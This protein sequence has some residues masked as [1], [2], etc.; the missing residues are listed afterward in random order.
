M[1]HRQPHTGTPQ[2]ILGVSET[3]ASS[4]LGVNT[5]I[6]LDEGAALYPGECTGIVAGTDYTALY[7]KFHNTSVST[8]DLATPNGNA[9]SVKIA[10]G[11]DAGT[12]SAEFGTPALVDLGGNPAS[13]TTVTAAGSVLMPIRLSLTPDL[14]C[15]KRHADPRGL[16]SPFERRLISTTIRG[17]C[18]SSHDREHRSTAVQRHYDKTS[19]ARDRSQAG[20]GSLREDRGHS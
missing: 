11:S 8:T 12:I 16:H 10:Y 13:V 15:S 2:P 1:S 17:E 9:A 7:E 3:L 4:S 18:R 19:V 14:C 20:G 6:Q 5:M